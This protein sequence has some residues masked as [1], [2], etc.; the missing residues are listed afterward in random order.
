[1]R[2]RDRF[3]LVL[4]LG[5][6][7]AAA[8]LWRDLSLPERAREKAQTQLVV[9]DLEMERE[10]S[11]DLF[12]IRASQARKMQDG[13]IEASSLDI[14]AFL[15]GEGD[16][17]LNA[18]SGKLENKG[19]ILL[20][21]VSAKHVGDGLDMDVKAP[22]ASWDPESRIWQFDGPVTIT[23]GSLSAGGSKG[24][25]KPGGLVTLSGEAWATWERH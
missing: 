11:G 9:D 15:S 25:A 7:V 3:L 24:K 13:L 17:K 20:S 8:V 2:H 4:L 10:I 6:L 21:E 1:M 18:V 23:Q 14:H 19:A 5:L 22:I 12:K 16:W